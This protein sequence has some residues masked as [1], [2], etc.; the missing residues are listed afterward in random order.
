[1]LMERVCIGCGCSD[2][3]ACRGGCHWAH[4]AEVAPLG[5]CSTCVGEFEDPLEE[6]AAADL[7][8]Q[9][10]NGVDVDDEPGLLLPGDPEYHATLRGA[11]SC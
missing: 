1:M 8:W 9:E 11:R 7:D 5:I 6:L 10:D 3:N 4:E 2:N